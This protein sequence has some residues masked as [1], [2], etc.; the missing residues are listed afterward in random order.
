MKNSFLKIKSIFI[1][2]IIPFSYFLFLTSLLLILYT[3]SNEYVLGLFLILLGII[4]LYFSVNYVIKI[5]R[6]LK[7]DLILA[8]NKNCSAIVHFKYSE[9]EWNSFAKKNYDKKVKKHLATTLVTI[10]LIILFLT[11]LFREDIKL[12]ITIGFVTLSLA[13]TIFLILYKSLRDLKENT[14]NQKNP[15][16][17]ITTSGILLNKKLAIS[18]HNQDGWLAECTL[19]IFLGMKC[20]DFKIRR[21]SGKG[22]MYQNFLLLI[23]KKRENDIEDMLYRIN[24]K[25]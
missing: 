10:P 2:L 8:L 9:E 5:N 1:L 3:K 15:E 24:G 12:F 6:S 21:S 20:L 19:E 11:V 13:T 16:A 18:Y 17:K 7:K 23:P 4:L 14:L 25:S 22:N